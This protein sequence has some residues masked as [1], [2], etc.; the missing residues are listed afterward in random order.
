LFDA[1]FANYRQ[2]DKIDDFW[3]ALKAS[4]EQSAVSAIDIRLTFNSSLCGCNANS[5]KI[6]LST[7]MIELIFVNDENLGHLP[8]TL[9]INVH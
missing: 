8:L 4:R 6:K 3:S 9:L 7:M 2:H 1:I 5:K